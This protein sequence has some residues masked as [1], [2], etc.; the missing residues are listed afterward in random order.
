MP[1]RRRSLGRVERA[2]YALIVAFNVSW[3][4]KAQGAPNRSVKQRS[5]FFIVLSHLPK[6]SSQAHLFG[7]HGH[8]G[9]R[10]VGHRRQV[11]GEARLGKRG[12]AQVQEVLVQA[13]LQQK[14]LNRDECW[15]VQLEVDLHRYDVR[16]N[17]GNNTMW[18]R[19][20]TAEHQSRCQQ[21]L[22]CVL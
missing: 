18:E 19:K 16:R 17:E 20:K 11:E 9:V 22:T 4:V 1:L 13:L 14:H 7:V 12:V 5:T 3:V 2:S 6:Y 15:V 8:R 10:V 21:Q